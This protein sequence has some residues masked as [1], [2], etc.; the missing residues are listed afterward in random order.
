MLSTSPAFADG[1]EAVQR[2]ERGVQLYEAEN[3]EGALVEFNTAY[4]LSGNYKL[5]YNIGICQS[6]LKDYAAATES[7]N[8]YLLDGGAEVSEARQKDVKDRLSKLAL[9][10][11]RVKV[12]TDAPAG[13]TLTIDDVPA[14]TVP[15]SDSI[16][17]KIGRR[18]FAITSNGRTVTKS[19]ELGSGDANPPIELSFASLPSQNTDHGTT[20]KTEAAAPSF[21][22][23]WWGLTV[24]LGGGAV[25]TGVLAVGK[26]NDFETDQATFGVQKKT[27]TDARSS[28]Q[29]F[30]IVTD[31]LI[32]CGVVSAGLSTYFTIDYFKKKKKAQSSAGFYV[33]PMGV[34]YTRSF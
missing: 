9:N 34:G 19:V 15:L 4:K 13:A 12:T 33:L 24:L 32:G 20:P 23:A 25:V 28:A 8:K 10:V 6:A 7:F 30:G 5:L 18:T 16:T 1:D 11:T 21:P 14:G 17:V 2:F 27:L 29:T 26:K 31:V 3:Y 22:T